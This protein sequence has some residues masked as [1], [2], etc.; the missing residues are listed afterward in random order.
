MW[1]K[2]GTFFRRMEEVAA[3]AAAATTTTAAA[4]AEKESKKEFFALCS[5]FCTFFLHPCFSRVSSSSLNN[6]S[7]IKPERSKKNVFLS[8][9]SS[10]GFLP[11]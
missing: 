8:L 10:L 9:L 7:F 4:A 3:A 11:N 5:R 1:E 6:L 2:K